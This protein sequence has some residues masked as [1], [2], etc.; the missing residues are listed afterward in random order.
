MYRA[1][2]ARASIPILVTALIAFPVIPGASP[3][4]G[5]SGGAALFGAYV[6]PEGG[7]SQ[8]DVQ[9][10]VTGLESSLGRGLGIDHHF[11]PWDGSF[12]SWKEPWDLQSGRTPMI[13]WGQIEPWRVNNGS[14]DSLIRARA[15]AVK[16]LSGQVLLRWYPGMESSGMPAAFI[17]AWRRIHNTFQSRGATNVQWVWCPSAWGFTNGSAPNYYP[18][19]AYADWVCSS[20]YNWAPGK[21]GSSW[22]EFGDIF[23]DFYAWGA[24]TGKPL[25]IGETGVQESWGGRKA[26]WVTAALATLKNDMP[27]VGAFVYFHAN[28][29]YDWRMDTTPSSRDA[30]GAMAQDP[31]F[32]SAPSGGALFGAYAKPDGGW[33]K[34]H[35]EDA[36]EGLEA[37]IGRKLD[38]DHHYYPWDGAF[39]SWKEPWDLENGRIPMISW[40]PTDVAT[41]NNGSQDPRIRQRADAIKA[42]SDTVFVRWFYEMDAGELSDMSRSP[43]AFKS[44]WR[45]IH[46]TFENRGAT[47]VEWVWCGTSWGFT[48]GDAQA[49][50]PGH[51]YVDWVCA[52]GYNWAPSKPGA[53]WREFTEIFADFY[54]WGSTTGKDLMVAETGVQERAEGEKAAW[55]W[56]ARQAIKTSMPE[57]RAFVYFNSASTNFQGISSDWHVDT[58]SSSLAAYRNMGLDAHFNPSHELIFGS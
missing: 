56:N 25:M 38:V 39:P 28:T 50:Y 30:F 5:T 54:A 8:S 34:E 41:I 27:A 47:N 33:S 11:Y 19:D 20:G 3:A 22:T 46:T 23:G 40:G 53:K 55:F 13:S 18:G 21:A 24:P 43:S 7:W 14:Q 1:L 45:R 32:S 37:Q 16:G 35:F 57:L 42:L 9:Q 31:L 29:T 51:A 26:N 44:A 48:T 58:S 4:E 52:D 2:P 36:I 15:D 49:Y 6:K 17:D 12:P 10:A